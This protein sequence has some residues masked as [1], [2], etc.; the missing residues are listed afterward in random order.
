MYVCLFLFNSVSTNMLLTVIDE[1]LLHTFVSIQALSSLGIP[2]PLVDPF[3]TEPGATTETLL[4]G[5]HCVQ[6]ITVLPVPSLPAL[7]HFLGSFLPTE[8]EAIPRGVVSS[9]MQQCQGQSSL[10]KAVRET[11]N[12]LR[13]VCLANQENDSEYGLVAGIYV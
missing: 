6:L 1:F 9:A 11:E 3:T 5:C 4:S 7:S 2:P 10:E 8:L 12:V 13:G